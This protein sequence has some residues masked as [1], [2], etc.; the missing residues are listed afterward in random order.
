MQWGHDDFVGMGMGESVHKFLCTNNRVRNRGMEK[1][2]GSI[3]ACP[4][5]LMCTLTGLAV[6][7]CSVTQTIGV[8]AW[9][10]LRSTRQEFACTLHRGIYVRCAPWRSPQVALSCQAA[11][12]ACSKV[13][14]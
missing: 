14:H 7:F 8:H 11:V 10:T 9:G 6:Q 12:E 13:R 5:G 3:I 2:S 4:A 1:V